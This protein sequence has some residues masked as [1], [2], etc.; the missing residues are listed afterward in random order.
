MSNLT[1]KFVIMHARRKRNQA[2]TIMFLEKQFGFRDETGIKSTG[3]RCVDIGF[4]HH[5]FTL[6]ISPKLIN[7]YCIIII[8]TIKI[9]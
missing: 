2:R 1:F 9:L 6:N 3:T 8:I 5:T 7:K 4:M